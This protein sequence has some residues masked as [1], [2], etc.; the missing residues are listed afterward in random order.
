MISSYP[1]LPTLN[2]SLNGLA[3]VFL[4]LGFNAIRKRHIQRHR[5]YMIAALCASALFLV[6]YLYYHYTATGMTPYAKQGISRYLYYTILA[7]HVPL[8]ALMIPFIAAAVWHAARRRFD[9]HVRITR[10][11]WPVWM[12]VSVTGVVIYVM[13]YVL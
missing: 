1:L 10:I 6:C 9:R 3:T 5:N 12:Y 13:L 2:A 11:L 7:T 8:A 4:L